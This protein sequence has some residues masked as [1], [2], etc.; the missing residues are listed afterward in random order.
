MIYCVTYIEKCVASQIEGRG[1]SAAVLFA[2]VLE[3]ATTV[4]VQLAAVSV[5]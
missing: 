2:E 1:V 4:V 5:R 3:G